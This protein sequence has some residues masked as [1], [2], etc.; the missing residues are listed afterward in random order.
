VLSIAG[1]YY[2][3]DLI[4]ETYS[5]RGEFMKFLIIGTGGTGGCIGGFL[6]SNGFD[7]SFIARGEHLKKIKENGLK[8]RSDLKGDIH[9][10]NTKAYEMGEYSDKADVIFICVKSYSLDEAIPL[11]KRASNKDTIVIPIL[12][13]IG[14]G[15]KI[16]EKFSEA[17]ILDGCI[18][19]VGYVASPGEIAQK[20]KVLKL[21]FGARNSQQVPVEKLE[22]IRQSLQTS[23]IEAV[24]SDN[25]RLDTFK[26]FSFIS[27]YASCGAYYNITAAGMQDCNEYRQMFIK[28]SEEIKSLAKAMNLSV[29]TDIIAANLKL[30]DALLPETT[31]SLQKDLAAGKETEIDWLIFE[32]VRLADKFGVSVPNYKMVAEKFGF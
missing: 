4:K 26:K 10:K 23:G 28:L 19:I 21:V 12:N 16:Y 11:V 7:T 20:G 8:I 15:D 5:I 24:V 3:M 2:K 29:Q 1:V 32:V 17:F 14:I 18:Y 27:P 13:G 9:I 22:I 30:L 25:I 6:A 31:A